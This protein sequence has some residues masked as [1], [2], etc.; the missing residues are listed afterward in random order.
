MLD[1]LGPTNIDLWEFLSNKRKFY[2]EEQVHISPS[3]CGQVG[4]QLVF[5]HSANYYLGPIL[6][7]SPLNK[8]SVFDQLSAQ[9]SKEPKSRRKR[10]VK[11]PHLATALSTWQAGEGIQGDPEE[12]DRGFSRPELVPQILSIA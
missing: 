4:Y 8:P 6:V 2:L 7:T 9:T 10:K 5:V 11:K 1:R 3:Q 12:E